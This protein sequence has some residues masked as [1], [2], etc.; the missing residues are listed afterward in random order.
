MDGGWQPHTR[1]ASEIYIHMHWPG[2]IIQSGA[3]EDPSLSQ[4]LSGSGR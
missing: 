1:K 4:A 2:L 3:G